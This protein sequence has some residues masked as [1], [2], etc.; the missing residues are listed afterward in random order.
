MYE[1]L[2]KEL[3]RMGCW[4]ISTK[5]AGNFIDVPI[6][7][8]KARDNSNLAHLFVFG[9]SCCITLVRDDEIVADGDGYRIT[10]KIDGSVYWIVKN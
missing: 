8:V 1:E 6:I 2:I 10:S 4:S 5:I 9:E 3:K 7:D